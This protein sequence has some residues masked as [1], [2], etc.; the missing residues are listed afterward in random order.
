MGWRRTFFFSF[1]FFSKILFLSNLCTHLGAQTYN[2]EIGES[3]AL[4]TE[5]A[6]RPRPFFIHSQCHLFPPGVTDVEKV[7]EKS[8]VDLTPIVVEDKGGFL[9]KLI[10]IKKDSKTRCKDFISGTPPP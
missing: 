7:E 5:T 3:C 2:P 4:P 10:V 1:F 6:R 9:E 8:A